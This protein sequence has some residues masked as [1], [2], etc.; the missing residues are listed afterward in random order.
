M[1]FTG[2]SYLFS[3]FLWIWLLAALVGGLIWVG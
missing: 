1:T 3:N 2:L